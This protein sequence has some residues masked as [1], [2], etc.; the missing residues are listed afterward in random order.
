[1]TDGGARVTGFGAFFCV[2]LLTLYYAAKKYGEV[3]I[4]RCTFEHD[5]ALKKV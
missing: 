3:M 2:G 1:M 4:L 5:G